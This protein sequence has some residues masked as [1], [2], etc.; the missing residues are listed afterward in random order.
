MHNAHHAFLNARILV[1]DDNFDNVRLVTELLE[2]SGYTNVSVVTD[3]S[4]ALT[5]IHSSKPDIILLDLHMPPP[6]G[7]EI[8]AMLREDF[9]RDQF[10]PVLVFTA[11]AMP[12][13]KKKALDAGASDFLTKPGDAA[14]ILLRVRNFLETR[15]MHVQLQQMNEW[16][17]ERVR[18]RTAELSIA[19]RE[20]L[21]AL[22]RAAEFRDDE[23][24]QHTKRVGELSA[25]IAEDLGLS[26]DFVD[27]I[28][29]AAPLHDVGKIAVPDAVLLKPAKLDQ[30]ELELM[31]R[32]TIIGERVFARTKSP[33]MVL[34]QSIAKNHHEWWDGSGYPAGLA[35]EAIP[36]EARIVAVADVFDALVHARP[37]KP[38]WSL[39]EAVAEIERCSGTHFDP[40]VVES[41]QRVVTRTREL[42]LAA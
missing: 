36:L 33:L 11:D 5:V 3:S 21:E 10:V 2:F 24:G 13:T 9:L 22:A 29:L 1:I 25:L 20:A 12:E 38:A 37:Y 40:K 39:S 30:N 17:D 18:T 15:R 4:T 32:H 16:L 27:A 31:R 26:I 28:R 35:G 6:D 34:A 23:T 8:L 42:P 7:F 41:F 14:E 19:R